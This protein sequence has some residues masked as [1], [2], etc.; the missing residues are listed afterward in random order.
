MSTDTIVYPPIRRVVTGHDRSGKAKII[1]DGAATNVK[2][3]APNTAS[4][5][6]WCTDGAPA[7]ISVGESA[8]DMG[9]RALGT[10]PPPNGTRFCVIDVPPGNAGVM[11]RTESLDYV[12]VMSGEIDME[13]DEGNVKLRSGDIL[14]QRGTNHSWL[15]RG[16]Q[17]ARLAF[18][19]VDAKPLGIGHAVQGAKTAGMR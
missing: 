6:V 10:A 18:V 12:I 16:R 8:E 14:I 11:H 2:R 4:T 17:P 7:D 13:L 5:L 9:A 3:P 15:N 1:S 19:L